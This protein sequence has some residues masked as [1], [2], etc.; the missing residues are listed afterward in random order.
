MQIIQRVPVK[1]MLTETSRQKLKD[2]FQREYGRLKQECEQLLFE[3]KKLEKKR[4]FSKFDVEKR[5]SAEIK[6][7]KDKMK[8]SEQLLEQL[9]VLPNDSE[10][11]IDEV[12]SLVTIEVGDRFDE[13]VFD[14]QIIIKDGIVIR[15]R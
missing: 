7:R 15:A 4:E 3:Q 14:P 13:Q 10:L 5:F 6:K 8:H 2:Q 12:E 1:Q 11:V 9:N